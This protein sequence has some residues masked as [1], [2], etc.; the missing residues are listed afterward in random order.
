MHRESLEIKTGGRGFHEITG[1]AGEIVTRSGIADGLCNVFV[2]HTSASLVITENADP[3]VLVD[4]ETVI[5]GLAPD[6]DPRYIHTAEGP[7]DMSAHVRSVLTRT[8]ITVPVARGA[9]DLGTW[10][11]LFLWEHRTRQHRRRIIVTVQDI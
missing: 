4:L 7:D 6:G 9:L 1:Q 2:R 10:Q 8:D 5:A 11:G 3:D